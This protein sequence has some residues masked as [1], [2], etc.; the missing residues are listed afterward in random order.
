MI[1]ITRSRRPCIELY[2]PARLSIR[3]QVPVHRVM[4]AVRGLGIEPY[5][6]TNGMPHFTNADYCLVSQWLAGMHRGH[7]DMEVSRGK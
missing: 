4:E 2:T 1:A 7:G 5:M 6:T 3:L